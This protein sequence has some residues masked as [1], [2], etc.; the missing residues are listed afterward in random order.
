MPVFLDELRD[1]REELG[2]LVLV[3]PDVGNVKVANRYADELG[4][5]LAIID[6]RRMSGDQVVS[7]NIVG[8]VKGKTVLMMDDMI[9]T[10]G[11]ICSAA[12]I[13]MD[14]GAAKRSSPAR[15]TGSSSGPRPSVSPTSPISEILVTDTIP[16]RPDRLA[17]IADKITRLRSALSSAR[18]STAFI[19]TARSRRCSRAPRASDKTT[20]PNAPRESTRFRKRIHP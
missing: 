9:S 15:R 16:H 3:S 17:P 4:G 8:D 11:T 7:V 5:E 2:D 13:V 1:R 20:R 6:K 18:P 19:T 12:E 10:A 14:K